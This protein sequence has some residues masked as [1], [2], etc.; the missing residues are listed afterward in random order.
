MKAS[1]YLV[2]CTFGI[3]WIAFCALCLDGALSRQFDRERDCD[4]SASTQT[5]CNTN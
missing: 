3:I 1:T 4:G 2:I 5:L